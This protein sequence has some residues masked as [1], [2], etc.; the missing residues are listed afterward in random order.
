MHWFYSLKWCN[1]QK[2]FSYIS[3]SVTHFL[4]LRKCISRE[5]VR[6]HEHHKNQWALNYPCFF[7]KNK[8]SVQLLQWCHVFSMY[9]ADSKPANIHLYRNSCCILSELTQVP[10][11][12]TTQVPQ[13]QLVSRSQILFWT[14]DRHCIRKSVL[15]FCEIWFSSCYR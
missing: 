13:Q 11:S 4:R 9:L 8:H 15:L 3:F 10:G 12:S 1:P 6:Y 14:G 2:Q 7:E 5:I